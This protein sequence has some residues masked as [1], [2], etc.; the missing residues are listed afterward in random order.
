MHR[1]SLKQ[2]LMQEYNRHGVL[3]REEQEVRK[4]FMR[5]GAIVPLGIQGIRPA[6]IGRPIHSLVIPSLTALQ[7]ERLVAEPQPIPVRRSARSILHT[8]LMPPP[9]FGPPGG[10]GM[11]ARLLSPDANPHHALPVSPNTSPTRRFGALQLHLS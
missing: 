7:P 10:V 2:E 4:V 8:P 11:R 9:Q 6:D 5:T 3:L 1:R